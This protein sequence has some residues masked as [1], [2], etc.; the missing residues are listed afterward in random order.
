[1]LTPALNIYVTQV[2]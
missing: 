2:T 1:M